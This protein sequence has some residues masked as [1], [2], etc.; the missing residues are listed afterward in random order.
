MSEREK[1]VKEAIADFKH[2][3]TNIDLA[4]E[5]DLISKEQATE[6]QERAYQQLKAKVK[7]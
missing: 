2:A 4:V 7:S 5:L 3:S 6:A 1:K